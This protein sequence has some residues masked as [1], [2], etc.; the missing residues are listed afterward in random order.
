MYTLESE[1]QRAIG[2]NDQAAYLKALQRINE[3]KKMMDL[4]PGG[5]PISK[6]S[7]GAPESREQCSSWCSWSRS[8]WS[9]GAAGAEPSSSSQQVSVQAH[10]GNK[11]VI[12]TR[13]ELR[14]FCTSTPC[15][16]LSAKCL[17][18]P[19]GM[20]GVSGLHTEVLNTIVRHG[21]ARLLMAKIKVSFSQT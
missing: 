13:G 9:S 20:R 4:L 1:R 7:A 10:S 11:I 16:S 17:H 18:D 14:V 8:S 19:W 5:L 12:S 6:G 15:L 21:Q 3:A 2:E